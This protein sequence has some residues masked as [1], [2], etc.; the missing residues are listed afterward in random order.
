M[1]AGMLRPAWLLVTLLVGLGCGP[2]GEGPSPTTPASNPQG[3]APADMAP[4][5]GGYRLPLVGRWR[6]HAVHYGRKDDQS[7]AVDLVKDAPRRGG[8]GNPSYPSWGEPI[9]AD[10]PG[11]VVLAIDGNPDNEPRVKNRY[12]MH[13]NFVVLDHRNG[14][15]SLFAHLMHGT[16]R[17]RV[18]QLVQMGEALGRCGNSGNTTMPHLHYQVMDHAFAHRARGRRVRHIAYINNGQLSTQQMRKGD[19]IEVAP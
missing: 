11:I 3:A 19:R 17:V 5:Q 1:I 7:F 18:G 13:G 8:K 2:R 12:E 9:V 16:V 4:Y 10:G 14:E 6:V 15:Y